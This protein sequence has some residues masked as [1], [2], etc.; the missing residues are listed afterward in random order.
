VQALLRLQSLLLTSRGTSTPVG[1]PQP[2][3]SRKLA[4]SMRDAAPMATHRLG[5]PMLGGSNSSWAAVDTPVATP[6]DPLPLPPL[7]RG[8]AASAALRADH[9]EFQ[10]AART[11]SQNSLSAPLQP[12]EAVRPAR[13]EVATPAAVRDDTARVRRREERA[14]RLKEQRRAMGLSLPHLASGGSQATAEDS[15]EL[16][17]NSSGDAATGD[18]DAEP[19]WQF[20]LDDRPLDTPP[21]R[22][23][24]VLDQETTERPFHH[25]ARYVTPRPPSVFAPLSNSPITG[26]TPDSPPVVTLE[27]ESIPASTTQALQQEAR[28]EQ[29]SQLGDD[30]WWAVAAS[31][32]KTTA[33]ESLAGGIFGDVL[34]GDKEA[35][36]AAQGGED[37]DVSTGTNRGRAHA[38]P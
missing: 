2:R 34:P 19:Q 5:E 20:D 28:T 33:R 14:A 23:V 32:G 22:E 37:V 7:K 27:N 17:D 13:G 3:L 12:D 16:E 10:G 31:G 26:S 15:S 18:T 36:V 38:P 6:V 4:L 29:Q 30:A 8:G 1:L 35:G 24:S 21:V 9:Q 11:A 25:H